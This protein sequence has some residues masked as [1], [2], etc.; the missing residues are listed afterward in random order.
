MLARPN[1]AH[2]PGRRFEPR[3]SEGHTQRHDPGAAH[4]GAT[5]PGAR[6]APL[7][8]RVR[9]EPDPHCPRCGT[10]LDRGRAGGRTTFWCPRCQP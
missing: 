8:H 3:R 5:R 1:T 6:P 10:R 9:D 2:P 4:R 7:A